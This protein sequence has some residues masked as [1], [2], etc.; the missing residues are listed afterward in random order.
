MSR[1]DTDDE[2][3]DSA[4]SMGSVPSDIVV[5]GKNNLH[6][7]AFRILSTPGYVEVL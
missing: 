2:S 5:T 1:S 7:V 4:T 3:D 6:N